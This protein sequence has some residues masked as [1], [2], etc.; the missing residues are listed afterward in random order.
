MIRFLP[1]ILI[2]AL[3]LG[4]L[5]YFR[6]SSTK[7]EP[8]VT[9]T[10]QESDGPIE[11]P[12]SLPQATLEERVESLED[13][14]IKLTTEVNR[15]KANPSP[16][17]ASIVTSPST[18]ADAAITE[19]KARVSA[20]EKATPSTSVSK[21]PLYIPMGASGGPWLYADWTSLNEYQVSINPDNYTGYLNMQLEINFRLVGV[22]GTGYVRLYNVTDRSAVA[23]EISTTST[24]FGALASA[25]FKLT[26]G[27]KLY[28][29]QVKSTESKD[30]YIQSAKIKVNF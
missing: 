14:I 7:E 4:G 26:S 10:Q 19:L 18:G 15:L 12:K 1:F 17:P 2:P 27:Q 22:P 3:L 8:V 23:S 5:W 28:T 13:L 16:S 20:L 29:V 21:A 6:S 30:L 25:A 11:V 24:S 9:K